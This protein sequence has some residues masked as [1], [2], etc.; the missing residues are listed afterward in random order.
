MGK[1][2][3]WLVL[4]LSF[5]QLATAFELYQSRQLDN[6][7][8]SFNDDGK[9]QLIHLTTLDWQP[10]VGADM[11]G[12]GWVTQ[13]VVHGLMQQG[14][15]A[16]VEILP[17]KRAVMMVETGQAD[18]LFPEYDI[19]KE[20]D[21][22]IVSGKKRL[23]LLELSE[24][25]P[26]GPLMFWKRKD[27]ATA[28]NGQY[29]S[30]KGERIGV[31]DGYENT[32]EFDMLMKNGFFAI[33]KAPSDLLNLKK[34]YNNRVNLIVGD[35][36]VFRHLIHTHFSAQEAEAYLAR[37]E[38]LYPVMEEK[39]LYLAFSTKKPGYPAILAGMN[40]QL[41]QMATSGEL[42]KIQAATERCLP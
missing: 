24:G 38:P 9:R 18:I 3:L 1:K 17:W 35:P 15:A 28:W 27:Y 21:S 32:T 40:E 8:F 2:L 11:C 22:D 5:C 6:N 13:V 37:L 26:S 30:I 19:G 39:S 20:A 10:Y 41:K 7:L 34:L 33:S 36:F 4:W 25:F 16:K 42:Q 29:E 31:V 14:Y 23:D 12:L